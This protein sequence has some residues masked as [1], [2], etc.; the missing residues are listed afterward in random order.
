MGVEPQLPAVHF[1][2]VPVPPTAVKVIGVVSP[3]QIATS[4]AVI[5]VGF[6]G[7]GLTCTMTCLH[8]DTP[9]LLS[10]RP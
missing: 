7:R 10:H 8:S 9:Q 2:V 5:L 3:A 1:K 6:S 4:E